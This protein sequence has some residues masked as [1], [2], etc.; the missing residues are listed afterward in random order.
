MSKIAWVMGLLLA[1]G[2]I[3]CDGGGGGGGGDGLTTGAD[4]NAPALKVVNQSTYDS[5]TFGYASYKIV[6]G[7]STRRGSGITASIGSS[8]TFSSFPVM[9]TGDKLYLDKGLKIAS[10]DGY[11]NSDGSDTCGADGFSR[12]LSSALGRGYLVE[13]DR[14]TV[15]VTRQETVIPGIYDAVCAYSR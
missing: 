12:G 8:G 10:P 14:V 11:M 3:A 1:W 2:M 4:P 15:T 7:S 13:N 5:I 6:N 9:N